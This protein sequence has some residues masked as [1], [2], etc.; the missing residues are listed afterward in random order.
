MDALST[1]LAIVTY[2]EVSIRTWWTVL[3]FHKLYNF[4]VVKEDERH[5][6]PNV[7]K[8]V[9]KM[10]DCKIYSGIVDRH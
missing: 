9:S 3:C 10:A 6:C 4:Q 7:P 8:D 2:N 1:Y 5:A